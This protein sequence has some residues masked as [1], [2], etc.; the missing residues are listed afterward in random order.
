MRFLRLCCCAVLFIQAFPN[1]TA[2]QGDPSG[3][4]RETPL[5]EEAKPPPDRKFRP[6]RCVWSRLSSHE[7]PEVPD[8]TTGPEL[9]PSLHLEVVHD[10][11]DPSKVLHYRH[12]GTGMLFVF[13]PAGKFLMGS[14]YGQAQQNRQVVESAQKTKLNQ[15]YFDWEQ[16]A[17]EV[18][19]S[20]YF[21]GMYEATVAEYKI[22]LEAEKTEGVRQFHFPF[23]PPN[24]KQVPM[25]FGKG[26]FWSDRQPV[27]GLSWLNAYAF[28]RWMGGRLPSEAEWEKAARGTDGRIFPWG[29]RFDPFRANTQESLNR[30][31]CEVGLYPGGRSPYGCFDMAGNA[32][33]YV[34][35]AFE[36]TSYR[37]RMPKDPCLLER[38]PAW[39]NRVLRGGSW[40]YLSFMVKARTTARAKVPLWIGKVDD[41]IDFSEYLHYGVRVV[42]SPWPDLYPEGW[43]EQKRAEIEAMTKEAREALIGDDVPTSPVE[44]G[45]TPKRP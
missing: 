23:S 40:N 4:I 22:F 14:E 36:E 26:K 15:S 6:E 34:L 35:D 43:I 13:V 45:E 17:M 10:P 5:E 12:P 30:R 37:A 11:A 8:P 38:F 2:A 27:V 42:M 3:K 9:A 44:D 39:K 7:V 29:N 28:C 21:I 1:P 24:L 33:E 31:S 19:L 32:Y 20:P 18:Y 41:S 25:H 16:P